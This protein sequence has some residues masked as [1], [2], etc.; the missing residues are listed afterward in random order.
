M[1]VQRLSGAGG[2]FFV[3]TFGVFAVRDPL[4]VAT[5]MFGLTPRE[6]QVLALL[7]R[8]FQATEIAQQLGLSEMTVGD[9]FKRLRVKTGAHT[10]SG[11]IARLLGWA[12]PVE[13]VADA[14]NF[15]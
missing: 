7:L 14:E 6:A 1:T 5:R 4:R 3:A 10:L 12:G 8:G 9:Y 2:L 13:R 11:V 15:R